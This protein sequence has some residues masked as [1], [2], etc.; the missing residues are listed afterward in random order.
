MSAL[1]TLRRLKAAVESFDDEPP[2]GTPLYD[3]VHI[4]GVLVSCLAALGVL[5]W[6]L[7]TAFI[8]EGGVFSKAAALARLARGTPLSELG[9]EGP[10]ERGAFEGW[11]GNAAAT[12]LSL[13]LLA[14]LRAEYRRA[15]RR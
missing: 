7:W 14:A 5:Y 8:F 3:P 11:L 13:L 12:L 2:P 15:K 9:Y 1:E 6:L 4:G 10:W